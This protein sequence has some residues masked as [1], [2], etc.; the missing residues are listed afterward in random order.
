MIRKAAR[1][2]PQHSSCPSGQLLFARDAEEKV[3]QHQL[4][5]TARSALIERQKVIL[6]ASARSFGAISA[7]FTAIRPSNA[8]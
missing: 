2:C 5:S 7:R 8:L 3:I 1:D 4:V 6:R